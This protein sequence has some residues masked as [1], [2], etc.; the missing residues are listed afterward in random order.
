[1]SMYFWAIDKID[2][3]ASTICNFNENMSPQ[4][5]QKHSLLFYFLYTAIMSIY[6]RLYKWM[7]KWLNKYTESVV[8]TGKLQ[9][10]EGRTW[11]AGPLLY[12]MH[13]YREDLVLH[14]QETV[15]TQAA[16]T[17][18]ACTSAAIAVSDNTLLSRITACVCFC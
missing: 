7:N 13:L 14:V 12:Y 4:S 5:F 1:L 8:Y 18:L 2:K 16:S 17:V 9:V 6:R 3:V 10:T 15:A 11:V